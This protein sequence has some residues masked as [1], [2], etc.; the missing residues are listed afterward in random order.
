MVRI[1]TPALHMHTCFFPSLN[2]MLQ[3]PFQKHSSQWKKSP[4]KLN[5]WKCGRSDKTIIGGSDATVFNLLLLHT[6]CM[7]RI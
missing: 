1:R 6:A 5:L 4:S 3:K 7:I 2:S